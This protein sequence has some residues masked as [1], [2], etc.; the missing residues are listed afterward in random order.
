MQSL[1]YSLSL[2]ENVLSDEIF[3]KK[4]S[5][6]W[7][8]IKEKMEMS[9]EMLR[10]GGTGFSDERSEKMKNREGVAAGGAT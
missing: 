9:R 8:S 3:I 4:T 1:N 2:N 10:A 6:N 5:F 7:E